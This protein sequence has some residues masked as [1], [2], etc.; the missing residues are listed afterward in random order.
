MV[1][2]SVINIMNGLLFRARFVVAIASL[3]ILCTSDAAVIEKAPD[4]G[5]LFLDVPAPDLSAKVRSTVSRRRVVTVD[6]PAL[7][8]RKA[9][10]TRLHFNFFKDADFEGV[11]DQVIERGDEDFTLMGKLIRQ[12]DSTFALTVK[13]GVSVM[14]LR[15]GERM[16][17]LRYLGDSFYDV[18]EVNGGS[19]PSCGTVERHALT[20]P[21]APAGEKAATT[22]SGAEPDSGAT[23]DVMVVYTPLS[24]FL[25]GGTA[26]MQALV[27]LAI[28][29]SNA[30]YQQSQINPRLRLVHQQEINY[31]ESG[32]FGLDL[33]RLTSATDGHMD[34]VHA[35][36]NTYGADMVSLFIDDDEYCGLAWLMTVLSPGFEAYGFSVCWWECATGFYTFAHEL[37][38]NM[39]CAHDRQ[40]STVGLYPYSFGWRFA[41]GNNFTNR[42]IMAYAPGARIQHFSNPNVNYNGV[43]TGVAAGQPNAAN[44]AL[45][46]NNAA[47]TVANWRQEVVN[48]LFSLLPS[49][50]NGPNGAFTGAVNVVASTNNCAWTA[51]SQS[52]FITI[53]GPTNGVGSGTLSYS[54]ATNN[55]LN[56][57]TGTVMIAGRFFTVVQSGNAPTVSIAEA[58]DLPGYIWTTGGSNNWFGQFNTVHPLGGG[59]AAQSGA[60]THNQQTY[61]QAVFYGPGKVSWWWKVSSESGYDFLHVLVNGRTNQSISGNVDWEFR[62]ITL[63]NGA[64]L[65]RWT[66]AKDFSLNDNADAAWLDIVQPSAAPY[67]TNG[68]GRVGSDAVRLQMHGTPSSTVIL[69]AST[70]LTQWTSIANGTFNSSGIWLYT[71]SVPGI[72]WRYY[73]AL[74]P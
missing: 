66:Y 60:I 68:V 24:R 45:S 41:T 34:Q 9:A 29:E 50:T 39:G 65:V 4:T 48:C 32:S 37:G 74:V 7:R 55:S 54:V 2:P 35:L 19:Y 72:P 57:R 69:Q 18:R 71:N 22:K 40:N 73:R 61:A 15:L 64:H 47:F 42:T 52:P 33:D 38:H 46:I 16:F 5:G 51:V 27:N 26:A 62:S 1:P 8:S 20:P 14:N 53:I 56:S 17:Q 28:D 25:A 63:T 30:A 23:I 13:D 43:P 67:F 44:N 11:V 36:R 49:I 59:D 10:G 70:D 3:T 6:L 21:A 58:V 12:S 31:T